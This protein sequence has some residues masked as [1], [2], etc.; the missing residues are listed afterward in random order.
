MD[1]LKAG[2]TVIFQLKKE[3]VDNVDPKLGNP[4]GL[5]SAQVLK[6]EEDT[7]IPEDNEAEEENILDIP[8]SLTVA[9]TDIGR[10]RSPIVCVLGMNI[11]ISRDISRYPTRSRRCWKNFTLR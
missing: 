4:S 8:S 9:K 2:L 3:K 5:K 10:L 1:D 7:E 11:Q 6:K